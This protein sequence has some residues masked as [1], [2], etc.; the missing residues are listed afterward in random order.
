MPAK[1]TS[2]ITEDE[3]NQL[4]EYRDEVNSFLNGVKVT[5][6]DSLYSPEELKAL[7]EDEKSRYW[8]KARILIG[9]AK[10]TPIRSIIGRCWP[11]E[12]RIIEEIRDEIEADTEDPKRNWVWVGR[13]RIIPFFNVAQGFLKLIQRLDYIINALAER[14][15]AER[16][17]DD[18]SG[19]AQQ[20]GSEELTEPPGA[21]QP[22]SKLAVTKDEV[23]L[24]VT[25]DDFMRDY[26]ELKGHDIVSK[27]ELINK[28]NRL[29]KIALPARPPSAVEWKS[30]RKFVF[31]V[32]DL[33]AKWETYRKVMPTLPRLKARKSAT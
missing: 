28:M 33:E 15:G 3:I 32:H 27:R 16:I 18:Q 20:P 12:L 13:Q 17:R 21:E 2:Q 5:R 14:G 1:N 31:Y 7:R 4:K 25:L 8:G 23:N 9:W 19:Q 6:K 29:G 26:C 11:S 22:K 24:V 30:G 10:F